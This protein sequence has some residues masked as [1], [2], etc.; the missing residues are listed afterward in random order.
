MVFLFKNRYLNKSFAKYTQYQTTKKYCFIIY[1]G[2]S[3]KANYFP[4]LFFKGR[5]FSR[6]KKRRKINCKKNVLKNKYAIY[7]HF[8]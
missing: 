2:F 6:T 1:F 7:I 3:K 4:L 8:L 5:F